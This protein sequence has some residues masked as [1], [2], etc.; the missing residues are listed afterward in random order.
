MNTW[1][2]FKYELVESG[3]EKDLI[4]TLKIL[5]S[6]LS[7]MTSHAK[8]IYKW[9]KIIVGLVVWLGSTLALGKIMMSCVAIVSTLVKMV[10]ITQ[11]LRTTL[12]AIAL[13]IEQKIFG[14]PLLKFLLTNPF[15]WATLIIAGVA[16][17]AVCIYKHLD[18][19]KNGG[20]IYH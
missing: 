16:L 2:K 13:I 17:I 8:E 3:F 11:T 4:S 14:I 20:L 15:G 18:T 5:N 7:K 9:T 19:I 12:L 6:L 1:Q 10:A